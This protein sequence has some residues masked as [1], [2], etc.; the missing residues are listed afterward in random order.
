MV[1]HWKR[2][3]SIAG[4]KKNILAH[5]DLS[6]EFY[7]LW[8]DETMTYSCGIFESP[9]TSMKD[10]SIEKLD[11]ICR[12]LN[13]TDKDSVLEIGTGWGSFAMHAA[14]NYNCHVTTTTISDAQYAYV[15]EKIEASDLSE[16]ITLLKI[17]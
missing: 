1:F 2:K 12:K 8:L 5:Y 13:L 16:K 17:F 6:N 9:D 3:N 15:K 14:K 10:A 4:S 11:R 7:Q